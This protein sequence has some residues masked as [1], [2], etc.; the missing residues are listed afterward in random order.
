ML[1]KRQLGLASAVLLA[2]LL[3]MN[4]AIV[5]LTR[6]SVP[7]RVMRHARESQS[8]SV[9][10]LGNSLIAA[11]FD[12]GAFDTGALLSPP[13]GAANLGL[14]SSLPVEQLLLF[15]YARAHGIRPRFL[16]YGFYDFQLTATNQL[17][18][19]ELI[20]NHAMLYYVEPFYARRFYS[21]SPHDNFQFRAMQAIP[22]LADRGAIWAKVE[23]LRRDFAQQ[24]MPAER[25]NRFGRVSDFSLLESDNS[26]DFQ[27]HCKAS[28][29]LQLAPPVNEL[30][31]EA[32]DAGVAIALVEMPMRGAHRNLFYDTACWPRYV[33]HVRNM[34]APYNVIYVDASNWIQDDSLFADPLHLSATGAAQFSKRLGS[35]FGS[36]SPNLSVHP[37]VA[38]GAGGTL[39]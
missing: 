13:R 31:H 21:L 39:P 28:L 3:V 30:I 33:A 1:T 2:A 35:L 18:T 14:G 17:T 4:L 36:N 32:H 25:I 11:G 12:E 24:G 27:R 8:A 19:S 34:L 26:E 38:P 20:G 6:N 15:R 22:M 7:R 23:I 29:D 5:Y 37:A 10:A 16:V 9:L